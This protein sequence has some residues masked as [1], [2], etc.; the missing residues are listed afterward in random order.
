LVEIKGSS[1]GEYLSF[2]TWGQLSMYRKALESW[3]APNVPIVPVLFTNAT[4]SDDLRE[5]FEKSKIVVVEV[6][7]GEDLI[8]TRQKMQRELEEMGL[9]IP[10]MNGH[11][12]L[13]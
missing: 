4:L 12:D 1:P 13:L 10:E 5:A 7:P 11:Q 2:A 8:K 9:P 3:Q 6:E